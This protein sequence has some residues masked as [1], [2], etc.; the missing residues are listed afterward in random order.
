M[1]RLQNEIKKIELE[2]RDDLEFLEK[3]E[4]RVYYALKINKYE[5]I[6]EFDVDK[7]F[8][9]FKPPNV[10]VN[11]LDYM[12]YLRPTSIY[13]KYNPNS[14]IR[15]L[16]CSTIICSNN[17]H[18]NLNILKITDEIKKNFTDKLRVI[19]RLHF[20]KILNKLG[21]YNTK[22]YEFL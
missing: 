9:P 19:E 7:T 22:Y 10:K 12:N 14:K 6:L 15:C 1:K 3:S 5:V 2:E 20:E 8:Y 13:E 18:P 16:C 11:F 21:M 17:W 4:K